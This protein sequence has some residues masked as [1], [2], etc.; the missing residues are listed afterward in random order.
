MI[1]IPYPG[2]FLEEAMSQFTRR[3]FAAGMM[4]GV[5]APAVLRSAHAQGATI[6]IGQVVPITGPAAEAG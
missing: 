5:A 1:K 3:Q 2:R 4:L 6:K